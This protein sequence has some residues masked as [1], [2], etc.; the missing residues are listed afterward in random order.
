MTQKI[1]VFGTTALYKK[2]PLYEGQKPVFENQCKKGHHEAFWSTGKLEEA[3]E[4]HY[5]VYVVS[6]R[7]AFYEYDCW[8]IDALPEE[9]IFHNG[10]AVLGK[11][12]A[13]DLQARL[14]YSWRSFYEHLGIEWD[15]HFIEWDDPLMH[16]I[17]HHGIVHGSVIPSQA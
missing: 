16:L 11:F 4:R 14:L 1:V 9:H 2:V 10:M 3:L 15:E 17:T 12:P 13:R 7:W 5:R 6:V 8:W